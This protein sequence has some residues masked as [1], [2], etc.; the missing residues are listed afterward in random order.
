M[1]FKL[2]YCELLDDCVEKHRATVKNFEG[3]LKVR[4]KELSVK[5]FIQF[6]INKGYTEYDL[7]SRKIKK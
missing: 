6:G 7:K 5:E 1:S 2:W 4:L 3:K